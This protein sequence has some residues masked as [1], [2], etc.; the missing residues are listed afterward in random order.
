MDMQRMGAAKENF[1]A[2]NERMILVQEEPRGPSQLI[3]VQVTTNGRGDVTLPV[4]QQ[5]QTSPDQTIIIKSLRLVTVAEL[6]RG[7][8]SGVVNAPLTELVNLTLTLYCEGWQK[9]LLMPLLEFNNT[10]IEGSGIPWRDRTVKLANWKNV[11]WNKSTLNWVNGTVSAG[12]PYCIILE[13]EYVR[14]DK[15][16]KQIEG[17]AS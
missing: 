10:F 12:A 6:S 13:V 9:G 1:Q 15:Y 7:P 8:N 17:P 16:G 4:V 3:E 5:L 11:D 2:F 14:F